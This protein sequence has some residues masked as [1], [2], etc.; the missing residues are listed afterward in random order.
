MFDGVLNTAL[1]CVFVCTSAFKKFG[2]EWYKYLVSTSHRKIVSA[3]ND[4]F[5]EW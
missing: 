5:D 2:Y 3:I 4:K 1:A